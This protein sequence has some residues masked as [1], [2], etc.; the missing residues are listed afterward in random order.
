MVKKVTFVG[1]RGSDRP[2]RRPG[3]ALV[4]PHAARTPSPTITAIRPRKPIETEKIHPD[5]ANGVCVKTAVGH[6]PDR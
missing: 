5:T 1:F 6:M 3:S 2:N 4:F